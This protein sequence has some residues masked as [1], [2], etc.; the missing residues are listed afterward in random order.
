MAY[1][2]IT[3]A[4]VSSANQILRK[5]MN[6]LVQMEDKYALLTGAVDPKIQSRYQ[7]GDR[8]RI[9]QKTADNSYRA[10]SGVL[11]V[12]EAGLL[13]YRITEAGLNRTVP[14]DDEVFEMR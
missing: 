6:E 2:H 1:I 11:E 14:A 9:C 12:A 4:G 8:L 5:A 7:I 10:A 13:A 3:F